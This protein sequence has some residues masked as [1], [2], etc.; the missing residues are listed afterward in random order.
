MHVGRAW[1]LVLWRM[2]PE[3][4][5]HAACWHMVV[6]GAWW[7]GAWRLMG[8]GCKARG[9]A[10]EEINLQSQEYCHATRAAAWAGNLRDSAQRRL[11]RKGG[12]GDVRQKRACT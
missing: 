3:V 12:S 1:R 5:M 9:E 8:R 4:V 6:H 10:G 2:P 11:H 7:G